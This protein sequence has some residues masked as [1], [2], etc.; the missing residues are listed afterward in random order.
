V[1]EVRQAF[2]VEPSEQLENVPGHFKVIRHERVKYA[3]KGVSGA[4]DRRPQ[5]SSTDQKGLPAP[6]LAAHST[7]SKFGDHM[8]LY[9][10]E[11]VRSRV[12]WT[13]R[14]S[15]LCGWFFDLARALLISL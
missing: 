8:P 10:Q 12:G 15:T 1:G 3:C 2:A 7:L 14:R 5:R 13:I 6:G 4:G 11:D 9:R